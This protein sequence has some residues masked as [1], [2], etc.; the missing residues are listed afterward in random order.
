MVLSGRYRVSSASPKADPESQRNRQRHAIDMSQVPLQVAS[1]AV[2]G[3]LCIGE[4]MPNPLRGSSPTWERQEVILLAAL[5]FLVVLLASC[6]RHCSGWS[7]TPRVDGGSSVAGSLLVG[8]NVVPILVAVATVHWRLVVDNCP[9]SPYD[10]APKDSWVECDYAAVTLDAVGLISARLARFDLGVS[11]LLAARG[12]STWLLTVT[13]GWLGFPETMPLHRMAGWWCA[14]QSALHSAAYVIFYPWTGGWS[15]MWLNLFPAALPTSGALNRLGLINF[16]GMIA[17]VA[18]LFLVLPALP[19][20]RQHYYH[21][22]QRLH[23][24]VA[25]LFVVCCALHDLP[26]LLFAVP[27]LANWYLGWR[28]DK[29]STQDDKECTQGRQLV[30]PAKAR[31]LPETSWV[32]LTIDCTGTAL[33]RAESGRLAPRG[34]WALVRVLPLGRE[35]HPLSVAVSADYTRMCALVTANAGDWSRQLAVMSAE[36]GSGGQSCEVE[37]EVTGPF[38]VGGGDWSLA[39]E[40]ALLLVAGGI[41]VLGWLPMLATANRDAGGLVH[42][43]WCVRTEQDYLALAERLPLASAGMQVT[44]FITRAS[45]GGAFAMDCPTVAA[46]V[47]DAADQQKKNPDNK[48]VHGSRGEVSVWV[49]LFAAVGGL[50]T[51]YWGW[52]GMEGLFGLRSTLDAGTYTLQY[53]SLPIMLI[54]VS[55]ASCVSIGRSVLTYY[56]E[57]GQRDQLAGCQVNEDRKQLVPNVIDDLELAAAEWV[58]TTSSAGGNATSHNM[59]A[60][61][62]D[63]VAIVRVAARNCDETGRLVVAAC[64]PA[65]LVEDTQRAVADVCSDGCGVDVCFS[66]ADSRW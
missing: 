16:F 49:S 18:L 62:P 9:A 12:K 2:F 26:I 6:T 42:L 19:S 50:V 63:L 58:T 64:G 44:I 47:P 52:K 14:G 3:Y 41:G 65:R 21:I 20:F 13:G 1:V 7:C 4:F 61:K 56:F 35:M 43:V 57:V 30:L 38:S 5:S 45:D 51:F 37:V 27:G 39:G 10:G 25:M 17:L 59:Q 24:P 8:L 15:S 36:T 29:L 11:L 60:G 23:L 53:R 54:L 33:L 22:F 55:M 40:P 48:P 28:S 46:P 66:G 31:L 34:E 32:E